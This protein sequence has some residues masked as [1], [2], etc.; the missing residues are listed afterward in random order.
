MDNERKYEFIK[1]FER[2]GIK[3]PAER[4]G[5]FSQGRHGKCFLSLEADF[6]EFARLYRMKGQDEFIKKWQNQGNDKKDRLY[7]S[8]EDLHAYIY[9]Y[10]LM[11]AKDTLQSKDDP[12]YWREEY[13]LRK[14]V[15]ENADFLDF[16]TNH[17]NKANNM[18]SKPI[19]D[20]APSDLPDF[21]IGCFNIAKIGSR[22]PEWKQGIVSA[23]CTPHIT[24]DRWFRDGYD[25]VARVQKWEFTGNKLIKRQPTLLQRAADR[26]KKEEIERFIGHKLNQ[27][28]GGSDILF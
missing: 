5:G 8:R 1:P 24:Y 13:G 7:L 10:W 28:R 22:F 26:N 6:R 17:L 18:L 4:G 12:W 11:N 19:E 3:F 21:F 14:P 25:E 2:H 16:C 20:E 15:K 27:G 23:D 9:A